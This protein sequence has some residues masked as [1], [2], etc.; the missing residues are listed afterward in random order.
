MGCGWAYQVAGDGGRLVWH[1][2]QRDLPQPSPWRSHGTGFAQETAERGKP[3]EEIKAE[4]ARQ[5]SLGQWIDPSEVA[6]MAVFLASPKARNI[7]D[8]FISVDGNTE[9]LGM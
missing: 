6:D 7:S 8:Q 2:R 3:A 1:S 5:T 4:H 9:T